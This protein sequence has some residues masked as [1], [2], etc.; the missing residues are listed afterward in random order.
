MLLL[1]SSGTYRQCVCVCV[2][3]A[4]GGGGGYCNLG[5]NTVHGIISSIIFCSIYYINRKCTFI[6]SI[7]RL[8]NDSTAPNC[9]LQVQN[10]ARALFVALTDIQ[11]GTELRYNYGGGP[12]PWRGPTR[13]SLEEAEEISLDAVQPEKVSMDASR[14]E[15]VFLDQA[16]PEKVSLDTAQSDELSLDAAQPK[17]ASLD[18]ALSQEV[19]L[20]AAAQPEEVSLDVT[21]QEEFF[22]GSAQPKEVSLDAAEPDEIFPASA[23]PEKVFVDTGQPGEIS[24]DPTHPEESFLDTDQPK[25]VSLE[26]EVSLDAAQPEECFPGSAQ[27]GDVSLDAAQTGFVSLD[28]AQPEEVSLDSVQPEEVSLDTAQ[29]E[30]VSP[31]SVPPEGVFMGPCEPGQACFEDTDRPEPEYEDSGSE[32]EPHESESTSD[33]MSDWDSDASDVCDHQEN[34][35]RRYSTDHALVNDEDRLDEAATAKRDENNS[36]SWCLEPGNDVVPDSD[37][38]MSDIIELQNSDRT[39]SRICE[40]GMTQL[41]AIPLPQTSDSPGSHV[42]KHQEDNSD[43]VDAL[44]KVIVPVTNNKGGRQWD[45]KHYC[46]F[47]SSSQ[48][49]LP[50]HFQEQHMEEREV[51]DYMRET[52]KTYKLCKIALLRN[53]GNHLHNCEVTREGKG[54]LVVGYRP[55]YEVDAAEYGPCEQCLV[56]LTKSDLWKHKKTC[57]AKK[58]GKSGSHSKHNKPAVN[59]NFLLPSPRGTSSQL[60]VIVDSMATDHISRVAKSDSLIWQIGE[61]EFMKMGHDVDQHNYIRQKMRELSRLL[62]QLRADY[63]MADASLKDFIHPEKFRGVVSAS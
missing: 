32:Y 58:L 15:K 46:L 39:R 12:Y 45:K 57:P 4:Q 52:N 20:D 6:I 40:A 29:P 54:V 22:T 26:E 36:R 41:E 19:S 23:Q 31:G 3:W 37:S 30:E 47:C 59:S 43:A 10:G 27:P 34:G 49:K 11:K 5:C 44:E 7:G 14:P 61:K 21:Q 50:R 13:V 38:E 16:Q 9:R 62:I 56:Y 60:Q 17:E 53:K 1:N 35:T 51:I 48:S 24:L 42:D 55:T 28:S 2:A 63:K 18:P 33:S 8:I 25:E